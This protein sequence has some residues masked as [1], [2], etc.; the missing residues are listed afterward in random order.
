LLPT[1]TW[2]ETTT[3]LPVEGNNYKKF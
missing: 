2:L 3:V 1:R